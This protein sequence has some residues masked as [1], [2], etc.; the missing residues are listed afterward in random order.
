MKRQVKLTYSQVKQV[1]T[2]KENDMDVDKDSGRG[3]QAQRQKMGVLGAP[4]AQLKPKSSMMVS[5]D[6]IVLINHL[7]EVFQRSH[8]PARRSEK[9]RKKMR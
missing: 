1:D 6:M 2:C 8:T 4:F 9:W 3:Q 7:P 5:L